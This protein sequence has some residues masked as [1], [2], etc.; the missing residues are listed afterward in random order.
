MPQNAA[1]F[2]IDFKR[3][4][5]QAF[6]HGFLKGLAAPVMLFHVEALSPPRLVPPVPMPERTD[7]EA[8][9]ADWRRVGSDLRAA[10]ARHGEAA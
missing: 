1:M 3:T 5:T 2:L 4:P 10:L 7:A 6:R 9:A 8:L